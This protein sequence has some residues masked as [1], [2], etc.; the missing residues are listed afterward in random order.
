MERYIVSGRLGEGAHGIVLKAIDKVSMKVVAIKRLSLK[1]MSE[2]GLP[3]AA[4]RELLALRLIRHEYVAN[5]V[6]YFPQGFSLI[7][8]CEYFPTD[9]YEFLRSSSKPLPV[10]HVKTCTI[11]QL[12]KYA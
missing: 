1:N 10:G 2:Q 7:L 5:L 11:S 6:D 8:I 12:L 4:M 9:L 3:N